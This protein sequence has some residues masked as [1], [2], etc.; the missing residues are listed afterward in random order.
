MSKHVKIYGLDLEIDLHKEDG[1]GVSWSLHSNIEDNDPTD[2]STIYGQIEEKV[3][4]LLLEWI[5]DNCADCYAK[6]KNM[7]VLRM[8]KL[9][10]A[11]H[12]NKNH[13]KMSS[14]LKTNRN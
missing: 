10:N 2:I 14:H 13:K 9:V 12:N 7:S 5:K 1:K 4:G 6:A 8:E 11:C 3:K